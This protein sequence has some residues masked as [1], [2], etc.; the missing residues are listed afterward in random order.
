MNTINEVYVATEPINSLEHFPSLS[1]VNNKKRTTPRVAK[2]IDLSNRDEFMNE[3]IPRREKIHICKSVKEGGNCSY[4]KRCNSA[5]FIDELVTKDC[6]FKDRCRKVKIFKDNIKNNDPLDI[7]NFIHPNED[8]DMYLS[9]IGV[10]KD[11]LKRPEKNPEESHFTKMC[12]SFF[13][14]KECENKDDCK[15]AHSAEQLKVFPC[16]FKAKCYLVVKNPEGN[17][18][19]AEGCKKLC[20]FQ[21]EGETINNYEIRVINN[22]KKPVSR[23][24]KTKDNMRKRFD[25]VIENFWESSDEKSKSSNET[26]KEEGED[27]IVL[28]VPVN[29]AMDTLDALLKSGNKNVQLNT[30]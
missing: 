25:K 6:G 15:Y 20:Y 24:Y 1:E 13:D 7:C 12:N 18:V 10:N 21:H 19:Q 8:I 23:E 4:G 16:H 11:S 9:R 5:H 29:M 27:K 28:N 26:D 30:Y 17:Y 14:K 2:I 3:Q 22:M